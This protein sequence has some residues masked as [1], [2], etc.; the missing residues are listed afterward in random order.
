M[1]IG[2]AEDFTGTVS[3]GVALCL[4]AKPRPSYDGRV[5]QG[6]RPSPGQQQQ[7][8][9]VSELVYSFRDIG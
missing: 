6:S 4:Q 3:N 9:D 7:V 1:E 8:A 2:R 5:G